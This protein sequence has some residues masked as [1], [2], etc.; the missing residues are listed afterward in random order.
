MNDLIVMKKWIDNPKRDY[1]TGHA[2][3]KKYK[4]GST[5]DA[6]FEA[7]A[8][9]PNTTAAN[10]LFQKV[11]MIYHKLKANPKF[12]ESVVATQIQ[13]QKPIGSNPTPPRKSKVSADKKDVNIDRNLKVLDNLPNHLQAAATRIKELTPLIGGLKAKLNA[14]PA[15]AKEDA[16]PLMQELEKMDTE[17][18]NLWRQ[19][20]ENK[21]APSRDVINDNKMVLT[22]E[23]LKS[24][25][26]GCK[27]SIRRIES[28]LPDQRKNRPAL[29]KKSEKALAKKQKE[30]DAFEKQLDATS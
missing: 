21:G 3:Y 5:Y 14:L 10:M 26:K 22:P 9:K 29:A 18:R 16:K 28:K 30:L 12:L 25:I 13:E 20:D 15:E 27:D 2:L 8:S 7:A 1:A 19:I 17:K 24:K 4:V 23:L 6:F 11:S